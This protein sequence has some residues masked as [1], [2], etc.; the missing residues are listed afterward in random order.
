MPSKSSTSKA[1]RLQ[2]GEIGWLGSRREGPIFFR[3]DKYMLT[4][5]TPDYTDLV[6]GVG[7]LYLM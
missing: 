3:A 4:T 6:V 5:S 7:L 1:S 2:C